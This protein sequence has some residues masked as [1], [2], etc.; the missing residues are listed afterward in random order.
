MDNSK[1][2]YHKYKKK[3]VDLKNFTLSIRDPW[4]L[5]IQEGKKTV[6]GRIGNADKFKHWLDQT[7]TFYNPQRKVQVKVVAIRH[8]PDLE[9]YLDAEGYDKVLPGVE[10]KK[11]AKRIYNEFYPDELIKKV[12]GMVAIQFVLKN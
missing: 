10:S 5:Y 3:Y 4:L 7:V 11:E 9:T 1:Q 12:G 6:E 2:K 8:Y